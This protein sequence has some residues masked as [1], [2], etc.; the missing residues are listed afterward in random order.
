[1][2]SWKSLNFGRI[3]PW[4]VELA[5]LELLKFFHRLIMGKILLAL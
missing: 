5:A 2:K 1:M 4:A 3:R